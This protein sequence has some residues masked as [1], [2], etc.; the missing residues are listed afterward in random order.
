LLEC[1]SLQLG[2]K[3]T[4]GGNYFGGHKAGTRPIEF[5]FATHMV[6]L[7]CPSAFTLPWM[8][9]QGQLQSQAQNECW[10]RQGVAVELCT[11]MPSVK[12]LLA[13]M[14]GDPAFS[15]PAPSTNQISDYSRSVKSYMMRMYL[16][17]SFERN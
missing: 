16:Q 9:V 11:P 6:W 8:E 10:A 7:D 13:S 4:E 15:A 17:F 3:M 14:Y 12:Q 5:Q 1:H 2:F